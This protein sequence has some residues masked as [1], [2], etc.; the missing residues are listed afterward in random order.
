MDKLFTISYFFFLTLL[1]RVTFLNRKKYRFT[2][3]IITCTHFL[4]LGIYSALTKDIHLLDYFL[5]LGLIFSF[6]GDVFLGLKD[7]IKIGFILGVSS[8]SIAQLYYL[9][10]LQI[11]NF[12]YIPFILSIGF[13][14]LFWRYVTD[15]QKIEFPSKVYF[16]FVYIF[17]LSSSSFSSIFYFINNSTEINLILMTSF[18][19]FFISDITLFHVYFLKKKIDY[20]KIVY[21]IFYHIAQ[22]LIAIYIYL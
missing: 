4:G 18:V 3:K 1:I 7:K 19:L 11:N 10:F 16:L 2:L 6:I 17:L 20:L 9:L 22:I 15:N 13:M 5:I 14:F 8:F 12:N 21:L